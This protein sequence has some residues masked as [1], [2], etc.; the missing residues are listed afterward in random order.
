MI[1]LY[2]ESGAFR[3]LVTLVRNISGVPYDDTIMRELTNLLSRAF[4]SSVTIDGVHV[5]MRTISE[6]LRSPASVYDI[7]H[8]VIILEEDHLLFSFNSLTHVYNFT[9][10]TLDFIPVQ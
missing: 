5:D 10:R 2:T 4:Y 6:W 3:Q 9:E 7:S 8:A 1:N